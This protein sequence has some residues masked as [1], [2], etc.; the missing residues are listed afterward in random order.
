L[1]DEGLSVEPESSSP[2][3][4]MKRRRGIKVEARLKVIKKRSALTPKE[5]LRKRVASF[6]TGVAIGGEDFIR[7]I[8]AQY[9]EDFQRQKA[10]PPCPLIHGSGGFFALRDTSG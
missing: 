7:G 6:S 3:K 10:R 9:Q 8:A 5:F 1:F 2:G 4:G